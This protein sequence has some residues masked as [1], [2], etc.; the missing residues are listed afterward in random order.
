MADTLAQRVQGSIIWR[1]DVFVTRGTTTTP[2]TNTA[3]G[4]CVD[5]GRITTC[6]LN[7]FKFRTVIKLL[8]SCRTRFSN[9]VLNTGMDIITVLVLI[10][11][12]ISTITSP[13]INGL[14]SHSG[15]GVNG[16]GS[17]VICSVIPLLIFATVIF[18]G[19]PF[20]NFKLCI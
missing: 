11:G 14:V 6:S 19:I 4:G 16:F 9:S 1:E 2:G 20:G 10:T 12:V 18:I 15:D 3:S 7:L 8:G 17:V 13:I 5:F